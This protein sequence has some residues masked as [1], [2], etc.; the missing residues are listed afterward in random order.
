MHS[1]PVLT[2]FIKICMNH[3]KNTPN[4]VCEEN[5]A[6]EAKYTQIGELVFLCCNVL[7][8]PSHVFTEL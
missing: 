7:T 5:I 2:V 3:V 4:I 8:F 6:F 1:N